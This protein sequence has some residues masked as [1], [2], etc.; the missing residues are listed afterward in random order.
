VQKRFRVASPRTRLTRSQQL[1]AAAGVYLTL[2]FAAASAAELTRGTFDYSADVLNSDLRSDTM[3]LLGNVRLSQDTM[4]I[5]A[6][7]AHA[8]AFR[9][10]NSRWSFE[11]DVRLRTVDADLTAD[12][13]RASFVNG[14]ISLARIEG[15]PAQFE[16]RGGAPDRQVRGRAATIEYDF[17]R[18][19]VTLTGDVWFGY[20]KDEFRCDT[21]V[22]SIR[23]ERVNC[24]PGS[25][26]PGRVRG[27]IRPR[28][29]ESAE[30]T[31]GA[32]PRSSP[33]NGA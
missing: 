30:P 5:A 16:Q 4:S 33:G 7:Q 26:A 22:Y 10:D 19:I 1:A 24:N 20:G 23:D 2:A 15:S 25:T 18:G 29:R 9:S 8:A 3:E 31:A 11:R 13:A 12:T 28:Q 32:T 17:G 6:A 14:Q 21:V 27:T